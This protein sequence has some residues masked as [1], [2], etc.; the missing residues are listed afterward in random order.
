MAFVFDIKNRIF[1]SQNQYLFFG[2]LAVL[3]APDCFQYAMLYKSCYITM[4]NL[5]AS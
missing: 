4:K 3:F 2:S 5:H 1:N